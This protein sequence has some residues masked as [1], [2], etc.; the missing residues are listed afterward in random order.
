[1]RDREVV[2][3]PGPQPGDHWFKSNSRTQDENPL[4][5]NFWGKE[6]RTEATSGINAAIESIDT[7]GS[8]MGKAWDLFT[9]NPYLTLLFG[10]G[11]LGI[12]FA[13]FR[14][15]KRAVR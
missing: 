2:N 8:L 9:A 12:G 10:V 7:V 15:V 11:L 3:S 6:G 1:M 5:L 13:V 4:T 14:K